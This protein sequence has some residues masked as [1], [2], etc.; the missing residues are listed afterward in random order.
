MAGQSSFSLVHLTPFYS[1]FNG[2]EEFERCYHLNVY[3]SYPGSGY[4]QQFGEQMA[5]ARHSPSIAN[6]EASTSSESS[7]QNEQKE[8]KKAKYDT[9][10]QAK[11]KLLPSNNAH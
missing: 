8:K 4:W 9:W 1:Y 10:S 2:N 3:D 7:N 11:Q 6:M 5:S